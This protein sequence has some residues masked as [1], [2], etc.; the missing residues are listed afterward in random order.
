ML[1]PPPFHTLLLLLIASTS[2]VAFISTF[3]NLFPTLR[4]P[5]PAPATTYRPLSPPV[6]D[7]RLSVMGPC[8]IHRCAST[9][10]MCMI[11]E[12]CR[13]SVLRE[14][15]CHERCSRC[16]GHL[17]AECCGCVDMCSMLNR[18]AARSDQR[19]LQGG[20][21]LNYDSLT[22]DVRDPTDGL[23]EAVVRTEDAG[24]TTLT[25]PVNVDPGQLAET[26]DWDRVVVPG[27]DD[28]GYA[29]KRYRIA[30]NFRIHFS[31]N[32]MS[33]AL[34]HRSGHLVMTNCTVAFA[35]QCMPLRQCRLHCAEMGA[36]SVRWFF[37]GCCQ[38]VGPHCI[39]YG[40]LQ[41][42]CEDCP[43]HLEQLAEI[44]LRVHMMHPTLLLQLDPV[45]E[46]NWVEDDE[47]V[48]EH[49]RAGAEGEA[50]A[51]EE[52]QPDD[53]GEVV[54]EESVDESGPV[55][56]EVNKAE[57]WD[58]DEEWEEEEEV[59]PEMAE[60]DDEFVDE[61]EEELQEEPQEQEDLEEETEYVDDRD[62][63]GLSQPEDVDGP[64]KVT[65]DAND[66]YGGKPVTDDMDEEVEVPVESS[67]ALE[68]TDYDYADYQMP[69]DDSVRRIVV[70]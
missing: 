52:Y 36:S 17:F 39:G 47:D 53:D 6:L 11:T 44:P 2:T 59:D 40:V 37:D 30:P 51:A 50:E 61:D 29:T 57:E 64:D 34:A 1:P 24:W 5:A 10:S 4:P 63:L 49:G 62:E 38:C 26:D 27:Y 33:V 19:Q 22:A 9:V 16:L 14:A 60:G 21:R 15:R 43:V 65:V 12:S 55:E 58:E 25:Y 69:Q 46:T 20:L 54:D 42:R 28:D 56:G 18:T 35:V 70:V 66:D 13:C 23:F 48:A 7:R 31:P 8:P 67:N 41:S 32:L 68:K 3:V 45:S